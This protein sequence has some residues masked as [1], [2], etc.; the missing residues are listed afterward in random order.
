MV[1]RK[2][3]RSFMK[4]ALAEA[5]FASA[6]KLRLLDL[7]IGLLRCRV[8]LV[9]GIRLGAG[10]L[11]AGF[12]ICRSDLAIGLVLRCNRRIVFAGSIVASS[13]EQKREECMTGQ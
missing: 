6:G 4:F 5:I 10:D 11:L 8:D 7:L 13:K 2:S 3:S 12:H 1:C 9:F